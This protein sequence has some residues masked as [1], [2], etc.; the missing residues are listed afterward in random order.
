[1][2]SWI[3]VTTQYGS[4]RLQC[5]QTGNYIEPLTYVVENK[6]LPKCIICFCGSNGMISSTYVMEDYEELKEKLV[7]KG[8]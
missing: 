5:M 3:E 8:E 4:K 6:E 2:N 1:M 7:N